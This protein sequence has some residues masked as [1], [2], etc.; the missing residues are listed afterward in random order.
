MRDIK[1]KVN[2]PR[3]KPRRLKER[4]GSAPLQS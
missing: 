3:E 1:E 2:K 4:G